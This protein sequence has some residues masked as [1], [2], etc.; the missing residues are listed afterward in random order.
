MNVFLQDGKA[1]Y[2]F[3][4]LCCKNEFELYKFQVLGKKNINFLNYM[5]L[6]WIAPYYWASSSLSYPLPYR[7]V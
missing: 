6:H 7:D 1:V 4:K 5:F 2:F 3:R